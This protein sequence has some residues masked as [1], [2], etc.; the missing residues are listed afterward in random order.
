MKPTRLQLLSEDPTLDLTLNNVDTL[1]C[2]QCYQQML[3]SLAQG[4]FKKEKTLGS[5]YPGDMTFG[6]QV[7]D[8][9]KAEISYVTQWSEAT[10]VSGHHL[11][12]RLVPAI[13]SQLEAETDMDEASKAIAYFK[14]KAAIYAIVE[15]K[16]S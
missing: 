9:L 8:I 11:E 14:F 15:G 4:V 13:R 3:F 2:A 1:N 10:K 5:H 16:V 12:T 6:A 7:R